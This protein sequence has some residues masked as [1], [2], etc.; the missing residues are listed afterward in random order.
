MHEGR[1][2]TGL[3][4]SRF[5]HDAC[6]VGFVADLRNVRSHEIVRKGIEV[7]RNLDHRGAR[8]AEKETG[9][10]AGILVQLPHAFFLKECSTLGC[11]LPGPE[12]YGVGQ[13]FLPKDPRSHAGVRHVFERALRELSLDV[14][15]WRVVPTDNSSLGATAVS[16]E[17][18]IQQVF[19]RRPV[20]ARTP[21]DFERRL[22]VARKYATR[23]VRESVRGA[24]GFY[25][26][27]MSAT[28]A[29]RASSPRSPSSTAGS[30]PTSCRRGRS[31]TRSGPWPTTAR[32]T[33][34]AAT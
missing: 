12:Q 23:L 25:V 34:C 29:T 19:V 33:R 15:G 30:R 1:S 17:P 6:G 27:S 24:D 31:P 4:D 18:S 10:G 5:E 7:L 3:Y 20:T 2:G 32:S 21:E 26:C 28:C 8:G 14:L 11:D 22:F 16:G 9:D 13:C